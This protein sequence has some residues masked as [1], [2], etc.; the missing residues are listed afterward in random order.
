[1]RR[2]PRRSRLFA[3][4]LAPALIPAFV[5][6]T[7]AAE[8]AAMQSPRATVTLVSEADT[9]AP[10]ATVRLGLRQRLADSWHTY[11]KNPGDAGAPTEIRLTL[12]AGATAGAIVWPGPSRI[13]ASAGTSYGYVGEIVLPLA[14]TVPDA[15]RPG[16][17][18]AIE[19]EA[20]WLVCAEACI[21]ESGRFRL[22]LPVTNTVRATEGE[23]AE[24]FRAA[25]ARMPQ[26]SPWPVEM[27]AWNDGLR[28]RLIGEGLEAATRAEVFPDEWGLIDP[29]QPTRLIHAEA[30]LELGV[31]MGAAFDPT[32]RLTGVLA[33]ADETGATRWFALDAR[34]GAPA[35]GGGQG[36]PTSPW[37]LAAFAFLGGLI[38]NS[39]PCVFP[40]LAMKATSVARLGGGPTR[41]VRLAALLYTLGVLTA[42]AALAALLLTLRAGGAAVGWGFQFQSPPFIAAMAWLLM[43]VGLNLSG[44][45]E[46]RAPG[47]AIFDRRGH[48][49]SFF[50]GLLAVVV[51]TPCTAP[52]MGVAIGAAL[53]LP[54]AICL[55][56][57]LAMG[58]GLAA[59]YASLA[60][61]PRLAALLPRPGPWMVRLRQGMAFPMYG[62]AAWLLWVL[63]RQSGD[64][65]LLAGL[66]GAVL[67]GFAAWLLGLAQGGA[68]P[69]LS[70]GLALVAML[71]AGALL[72]RV[73]AASVL[74]ASAET[75]ERFSA[76][77][78][79]TLRNSGTPAFVNMTADW[80]LS[81]LV[82]ERVALSTATVQAALADRGVVYLKG[83]WTRQ[84]PE[85]TAFLRGF[86]RD[87]VPFYALYPPGGGAPTVLPPLLTETAMLDAIAAVPR[88]R[89]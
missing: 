12:P 34:L 20:D 54:P 84:D 25:D 64:A 67:V 19:A 3:A 82:N 33:L 51:A 17:G 45:F 69:K 38:L 35:A 66:A 85:I 78:L 79:Q 9:V 2:P 41:E 57:F 5:P 24:A 76:E 52:F 15:A 87:G 53:A 23:V 44:V 4:C 88:F 30:R 56:L 58:L 28:L 11:W 39:M 29:G 37:K 89:N 21:P 42:F 1:M 59:P 72:P 70:G 6:D 60:A 55:A 46:V 27:L 32:R 81:C 83:D 16:E 43:A 68:R 61:V 26:P 48:S 71:I 80:C 65:G 13:A 77:R 50:T 49:G 47:L 73:D 22:V 31:A 63:A 62:S 18:F 36:A 86:G 40:V 8:S 7:L 10:G 74:R 14:V 75:G